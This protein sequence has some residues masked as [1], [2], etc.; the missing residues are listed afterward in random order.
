[1]KI[2]IDKYQY[3]VSFSEEEVCFIATVTEF[4]YLTAD[5]PTQTVA[6]EELRVVVSDAIDILDSE[7]K[8]VPEPISEREYRGNIT[9]R[10]LPETHRQ[11][12]EKA[13]VAGCSLNQFLTSLIEKNMNADGIER[14]T[15]RIEHFTAEL[16]ALR[17]AGMFFPDYYNCSSPK[18]G[19]GAKITPCFTLSSDNSYSSEQ[20]I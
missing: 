11:L 16:E 2:N 14:A 4:P 18:V 9:L 7:G 19:T 10:L 5:G 6:L 20:R 8:K 1:M 12:A 13:R 17:S 15:S 3:Q